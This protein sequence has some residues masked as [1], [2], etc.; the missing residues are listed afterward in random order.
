MTVSPSSFVANTLASE[1]RIHAANA[2]DRAESDNGHYATYASAFTLAVANPLICARFWSHVNK[3]GPIHPVL[4]TR[5]WLWTANIVGHGNKNHPANSRHGQF[6]FR[7]SGG[8]RQYHVYA[9]RF[10]W[11]IAHGSIP[12]GLNVLHHCD[13]PPCVNDTHHF[14]GTQA[15]NMKDA[16][17][18][19]RFTVPRTLKLSLLERLEIM[20]AP[21][22]RQTGGALARRF[23]VSKACIHFIRKGRFVGSGVAPCI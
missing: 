8:S 16:A 5:C 17:R 13:V 14:L 2:K 3:N 10:A 6:T 18:K 15:D 4:G 22:D 12:I 19:H 23:G 7:V 1:Q 11:G 21:S 20:R 9:H